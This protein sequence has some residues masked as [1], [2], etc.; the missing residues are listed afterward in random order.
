MPTDEAPL[1]PP[2]EPFDP[3]SLY[4]L[5][6]ARREVRTSRFTPRDRLLIK[7]AA[8]TTFAALSAIALE[9]TA[10]DNPALHE[11]DQRAEVVAY[12]GE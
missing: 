11:Q 8:L 4:L 5:H 10:D 2:V 12:D 7:L 6:V 3:S 1:H 9:S